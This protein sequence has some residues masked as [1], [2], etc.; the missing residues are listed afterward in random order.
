MLCQLALCCLSALQSLFIAARRYGIRTAW[1]FSR[2]SWRWTFSTEGAR[3]TLKEERALPCSLLLPGRLAQWEGGSAVA[4]CPRL[5]PITQNPSHVN[6]AALKWPG[7]HLPVVL[8]TGVLSQASYHASFHL[9][10]HTPDPPPSS[11]LQD[12]RGAGL[13]LAE[14]TRVPGHHAPFTSQSPSA[15]VPLQ[16]PRSMLQ[17]SP[18]GH[19]CTAWILEGRFLQISSS[20]CHAARELPWH[21]VGSS[22]SL[23]RDPVW[24]LFF[25]C[26]PLPALG[27]PCRVSFISY[28]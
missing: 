26:Y 13:L 19:L 9:Q 16:Q 11:A 2:W 28:T 1:S 8:P 25:S 15:L 20:A 18:A 22:Y 5:V 21:L 14:H 6:L 10:A 27:L 7:H 24:S 17:P 12:C 4:L 23:G 3:G